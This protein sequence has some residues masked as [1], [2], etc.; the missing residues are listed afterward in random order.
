MTSNQFEALTIWI[1]AEV[2]A[3]RSRLSAGPHVRPLQEAAQNAM[4]AARAA[5]VEK[6]SPCPS[7]VYICSDPKFCTCRDQR[8]MMVCP[9]SYV[10]MT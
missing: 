2:K 10:E 4:S 9:Y 5:L 6:D 8:A 3:Q 1:R 7:T